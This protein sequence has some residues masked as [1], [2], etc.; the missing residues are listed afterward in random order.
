MGPIVYWQGLLAMDG[1]IM[2]CGII[3]SCQSAASSEIAK[4]FWTASE[5]G[6]FSAIGC[7]IIS[8][9]VVEIFMQKNSTVTKFSHLM[10]GGLVI[11]PHD[12]HNVYCVFMCTD[13]IYTFVSTV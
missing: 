6:K 5:M 8:C 13:L 12:V 2:C 7:S 9:L 4:H 10:L 11:M 3:S 1:S